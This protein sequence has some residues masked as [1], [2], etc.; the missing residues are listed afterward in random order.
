MM[1]DDIK[2]TSL[3]SN[4]KKYF[5]PHISV[6]IKPTAN[7]KHVNIEI[8][9]KRFFEDNSYLVF[10]GSDIHLY[11][12]ILSYNFKNSFFYDVCKNHLGENSSKY[13]EKLE[14]IVNKCINKC[15]ISN[16]LYKQTNLII[17]KYY[18][19]YELKRNLYN[20]FGKLVVKFDSDLLFKL[21]MFYK[22]I[23]YTTKGIPDL[24]IVKNNKFAF[25]EVKSVNDSLSP[26]QYF[27]FEEYLETVSD[28]IY[29]VRFT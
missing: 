4:I 5:I 12:S 13:L 24:F 18:S 10:L 27:F 11:F 23:G 20:D 15:K 19:K 9:A 3:S 21:M 16:N 22:K 2:N 29:L 1:I 25:V 14:K 28:N 6:Y 17:Q 26:E 7:K 8:L